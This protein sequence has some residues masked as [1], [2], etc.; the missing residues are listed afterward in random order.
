MAHFQPDHIACKSVIS[1][2]ARPGQQE[3]DMPM[4]DNFLTSNQ[5]L[6]CKVAATGFTLFEVDDKH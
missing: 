1:P 6:I 4:P 2:T 3:N 5:S